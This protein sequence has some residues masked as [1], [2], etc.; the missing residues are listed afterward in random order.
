MFILQIVRFF[1]VFPFSKNNIHHNNNTRKPTIKYERSSILLWGKKRIKKTDKKPG[2]VFRSLIPSTLHIS[3]PKVSTWQWK[4]FAVG[5]FLM[6]S[7]K[8]RLTGVNEKKD[9]T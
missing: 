5:I 7:D 2:A 3:V 9:R 6:N 4:P 8:T 1:R